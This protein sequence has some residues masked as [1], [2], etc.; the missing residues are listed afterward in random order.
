MDAR[1]TGMYSLRSA[2]LKRP[3]IRRRVVFNASESSYVSSR[4]QAINFGVPDAVYRYATLQPGGPLTVFQRQYGFLNAT[5]AIYV[6]IL[7]CVM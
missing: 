4:S 3:L 1:T 6:S 5:E 2:C 7:I